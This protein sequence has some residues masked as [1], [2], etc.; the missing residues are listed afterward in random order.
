MR[1]ELQLLSEH[2][3]KKSRL[4]QRRR[5]PQA[6]IKRSDAYCSTDANVLVTHCG[7]AGGEGRGR[8]VGIAL[9]PGVYWIVNRGGLALSRVSNRFVV[10]LVDSS[11]NT[12]QPKLLP[13]LS[14]HDCTSAIIWAE[15]H[16]YCPKEPID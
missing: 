1:L 9:G 2:W 4:Q 12:S 6:R 5:Q 13:G 7:R 8:G 16:V 14:S 10:T 3:S 15:L 11:P